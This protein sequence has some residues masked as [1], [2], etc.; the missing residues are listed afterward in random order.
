MGLAAPLFLFG[1]A[2]IVLPLWLHRLETQ[3][4]ER[5]PFSSAMLL[6]TAER[7]VHVRKKLRYL[8][9]LAARVAFIALVSVAFAGPFLKRPPT[10][11]TATDAGT[12]VV[13]VD[14]SAS[15]A[16]AG[17]FE[18]AI[19]EAQRAVDEAPAD[20]LLQVIGAGRG[21]AI[22]SGLTVDRA[23]ARAAMTSLAPGDLRADYGEIM[24]AV[25]RLAAGLPP[26]VTLHFISDFQASAMPARFPD[27]VPA[28]I[29]RLVPRVVGT[30]EPFNWSVDYLHVSADGI[31]VG[32]SGIG[33]R[34]RIG[35]VEL[36]VDGAAID[37]RGLSHTG[38]QNL[39][40]DA[41]P[42]APGENRVEFRINAD[43][44]LQSD[45]TW[46]H[47]VD[48]T[49]GEPVA[50]ITGDPA[51][52]PVTYLSAALESTGRYRV[53]T[54]VPGEFDARILGR[55]RWVV[56]DDLGL[57]DAP[58]ATALGEFLDGG[59]NLLAF[60][61]DRAAALATLPV[62][63]HRPAAASLEPANAM[64]AIGRIDARHPV[65]AGTEGWQGVAVERNLAIEPLP[66]DEV[67][68]SL[69]NNQPF[70]IEHRRG[71]GRLLLFTAA[72][73]N[74][75]SDLPVRPVFVSFMVEAARYLSGEAAMERTH[76]AGSSLSLAA[77]GGSSGQV[78]D[79]DGRTIL[80][81]VDTTREQQV[82]LEK[83]GFY[84]VHTATGQSL[85]AANI[86][87]RESDLAKIGQDVLD[88][89]QAATGASGAVTGADYTAE[90]E[91][92][93]PLWHWALFILALVVICESILGNMVFAP[94][95][96]E[97]A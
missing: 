75:W 54:R 43:D 29:A 60:A 50:L 13:L 36:L 51:G 16:A 1:L 76:T 61:G 73:D 2:A 8:A 19:A 46:Y 35:D 68:L 38:H 37:T 45:N 74:R 63:G 20:A 42:W 49:A 18:Q 55:H 26:P 17:V 65:L 7:Q 39:H 69:A 89:W 87:P 4:S 21:L 31:D 79:P 40:F 10:V 83:T 80:S 6:E 41:P 97:R 14:T 22:A 85:V 88:E 91:R 27:V 9:L 84:E 53:E 30:G 24:Q 3:R 25:E 32:V 48:N 95:G 66:G 82:R 81:L 71:R 92:T 34:E 77:A 58:L 23:A 47:V 64:L 62:S 78:V 59:G 57:V 90:I 56:V 94:R 52:L 44:D 96:T 86:D 11:V 15:M 33:D 93:V 28:G 70:L 12:H 5:E 67:L 72:L